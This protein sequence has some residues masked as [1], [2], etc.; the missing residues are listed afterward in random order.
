MSDSAS[1]AEN[2]K[3]GLFLT[4][5]DI[6]VALIMTYL[7]SLFLSVIIELLGIFFNWWDLPGALHAKAS[8]KKELE[9]LNSDFKEIMIAPVEIALFALK[10]MYEYVIEASHL[11]WLIEKLQGT[12]LEQYFIAIAYTI[13]LNAVRLAVIVMSLPAFILFG[14]YAIVDGLNERDVRTWSGGR[15]SSFV[16]HHTKR[17]ITTF[18]YLPIIVYLSSPWS[19]HPSLFML[20]FALPFSYAIW[21][22]TMYFKKYM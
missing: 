1:Q 14:I 20:A 11:T 8:L 19:I 17:W 12:V 2:T 21:L 4:L 16:Y 7:G 3:K 5:L 13:E 6:V 18:I 22:A 15:E 10:L 9:W